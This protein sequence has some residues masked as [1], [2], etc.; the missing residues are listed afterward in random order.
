M[1]TLAAVANILKLEGVEYMSC[2]PDNPLIDAAAQVGIRPLM[3]RTERV[4]LNIADG[5]ARASNGQCKVVCAVQCA[6]GIENTFAGVAQAFSD[7]V[8]VLL[9][10]GG[11]ERYRS[12]L[13]P[14]FE[15]VPHYR[16]VTKWA[17]QINA[18]QRVPEMLRRA[19]TYLRMGK[20]G[21]VLL[22]IPQDLVDEELDDA[23]LLYTPVRPARTQADPAA[24]KEAVAAL[25]RARMPLIYAGQG[26]LYAGAWE[27]L[28]ALAELL[29]AP[30]MTT[31][32]GK[33]A[34]P[35]DHPLSI[36]L[37]AN[38]RTL[39]VDHFL[40]RADL[41]FGVGC[42]LGAGLVAIPIPR[43]K[44]M[45]QLTI[46]ER[47]INTQYA[48]DIPILGDA[49][50]ALRQMVDEVR[51]QAGPAGRGGD[52]AT[53]SEIKALKE[54]WWKAWMPKFTSD[55]I[56]INPYRVIWDLM[57]TLD[58]TR[59]IVTHDSG[60]PRD[61]MARFYVARSP[62]SYI[63]WGHSTQLG[64][65]LGLAMGAKLAAPDKTVVNVMGDGAFGMVG[66]DFETAVRNQIPILTILLN[67]SALG[68][69]EQHLPVATEKYGIKFL[70]GQYAKVA[71]GL[72]AYSERIEQ[73]AEI[74]PALRRARQV[75]DAG[76]P[77]LLEIIT[78]EEPAMGLL[79]G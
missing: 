70:S 4:A 1:K 61:Q 68:C 58:A 13:P 38:T 6:A 62:R 44:L 74:L 56:P 23:L 66:A 9:F 43:D 30:V 40:K 73:P 51:R 55:E 53:A 32:T 16:G 57:Q 20:P 14:L 3:A 64:T 76:R 37:G 59:S 47:D 35:E 50:L 79:P 18:A 7:S 48:I 72:G 12:S 39:A 71:D 28:R 34:F 49:K 15:A 54:R 77:A 8:P 26:V 10:A 42:S 27:E 21:P 63:G 69:Y 52:S 33:S 31:L 22:E 36:G 45:I 25:L 24:V 19:F 29:Q 2:F 60:N 5:Y 46:D 67:N 65:S 78:R 17:A 41:V 11:H 75:L